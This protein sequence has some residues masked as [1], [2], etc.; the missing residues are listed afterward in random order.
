MTKLKEIPL[1]QLENIIGLHPSISPLAE[2][3][4]TSTV[5]QVVTKTGTYILKSAIKE[6]YR[7]WLQT[8]ASVLKKLIGQE[9]IPV[10]YYHGFFKGQSSSHLIMSY[11]QGITLTAALNHAKTDTVKHALIQSFG[12]FLHKLHTTK[13]MEPFHHSNEWLSERLLKAEYYVKKRWTEG[14]NELLALLKNN[15]PMPIKQTIIHGDCTTDNVL[16]VNGTV[17][18]F[19]DIAGMTVGDPRY[20]EALAIRGF[21]H[22]KKLKEA[23]YAGYKHYKITMDEFRYFDEGLYEFF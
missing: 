13:I 3:G 10:P 2:Q 20:D 5:Y 1:E 23:F 22:D 14:S 4:S 18:K 7:E 9:F 21:V 8:E 17:T 12:E 19:I 11:E 15:K 16:V 6:K